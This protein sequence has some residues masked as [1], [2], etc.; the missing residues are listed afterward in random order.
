M[1]TSM[2]TMHVDLA[3]NPYAVL[4]STEADAMVAQDAQ[5]TESSTSEVNVE[6]S[7]LEDENGRGLDS[8]LAVLVATD[9]EDA[10]VE[11][12]AD[13]TVEKNTPALV[14][15]DT[16]PIA[17]REPS[18]VINDANSAVDA[19]G[20]AML[21]STHADNDAT[22]TRKADASL[23]AN[24]QAIIRTVDVEASSASAAVDSG[25][26]GNAAVFAVAED[27]DVLLDG[28]TESISAVDVDS[29]SDDSAVD[30]S[31]DA[32]LAATD[33][34]A[35]ATVIQ[36]ADVEADVADNSISD[37]VTLPAVPILA[38]DGDAVEVS[39]AAEAEDDSSVLSVV[40]KHEATEMY[41]GDE[42]VANA[43]ESNLLGND[44]SDDHSMSDGHTEASATDEN[45]A[46]VDHVVDAEMD[47]ANAKKNADLGADAKVNTTWVSFES[48]ATVAPDSSEVEVEVSNVEDEE[49]MLVSSES[50]DQGA[51]KSVAEDYSKVGICH[52]SRL[53]TILN[54]QRSP[55]QDLGDGTTAV[56]FGCNPQHQMPNSEQENWFLMCDPEASDGWTC[57]DPMGGASVCL[58]D[59]E[60]CALKPWA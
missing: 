30:S 34:Q 25:M 44:V 7:N 32:S 37:D 40:T 29:T 2:K 28:D 35:G 52:E 58:G 55:V 45:I 51:G 50:S 1:L 12:D 53:P 38:T 13:A 41:V 49:V 16:R 39:T 6:A 9:D 21:M 56:V 59:G 3:E 14:E 46:E 17:Q 27:A 11:K 10:T 8:S 42:L 23:D 54:A 20:G 43:D 36:D 57:F 18:A 19:E 5:E 26:D 33:A 47:D 60:S 31:I 4:A 48:D 24:D 15:S 22:V